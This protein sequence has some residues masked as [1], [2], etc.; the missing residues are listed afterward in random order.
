MTTIGNE[1]FDFNTQ[2]DDILGN[3]MGARCLCPIWMGWMPWLVDG[4]E[5]LRDK[6]KTMERNRNSCHQQAGFNG[7]ISHKC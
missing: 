4:V 3:T 5:V 7:I 2:R 1:R 6:G